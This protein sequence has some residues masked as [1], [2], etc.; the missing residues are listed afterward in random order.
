MER[1]K[2]LPKFLTLIILSGCFVHIGFSNTPYNIVET[3]NNTITINA[4]VLKRVIQIGRSGIQTSGIFVNGKNLLQK[5]YGEVSVNFFDA[6]PN[7]QPKGLVE[8][9]TGTF[10]LE[11]TTTESTDSLEIS[12]K[13]NIT[14]EGTT[15]IDLTTLHASQWGYFFNM[16]NYTISKPTPSTTRLC[17]RSRNHNIFID[18]IYEIYEGYPAIRKWVEVTN[19]SSQWKKIDNLVI[20]DI[21]ILE[22]YRHNT[23][24]T[25]SERG[26]VSSIRS[27]SDSSRSVGIINVSEIPS[28]LRTIEKSGSMGYTGDLF[29]WVLGPTEKFT[30]EAVF[31]FAFEGKT[32]TTI[33]GTSTPLD[34]TIENNFQHFLSDIIGLKKADAKSMSPLWCSWSNFGSLINDQNMRSMSDIASKIGIKTLLLDAGWA[35]AHEPNAIVPIGTGVDLQKFPYFN[36]TCQYMKRKGLQIG[37]WVTC[38]RHPQLSEDIK[39]LPRGYSLPK[40]QREDGLAMSYAGPW[41]YYY[42][43][44]LLRLHDQFGVTYFKQDLTNIKFG[45]FARGHE[46][47]TQKESILR[48]L[49]GLFEAQDIVTGASPDIQMELTHEIYWGTPGTPCDVA[50]LKHAHYFHIPPNDYS[51]AGHNKQRVNDQWS[52]IPAYQPDNLRK[53]LIQGCWNARQQFFAHRGLPLQSIEYYGA[54]TVNFKGSLTPQIQQRQLCSWLMGAPS[55]YAG[56][57]A[58]LSEENIK[59]YA[60]GFA[61]LDDLNNKYSIYQNFQYSGV[62]VPTDTDWHWWGKLNEEGYGAIVVLRGSEGDEQRQVN[63]PWVNPEKKYRV[64]LCFAN[65]ILGNFLGKALI[66]GK[67]RISLPVYSQEI[68]E[69][70]PTNR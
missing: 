22:Q 50:A 7:R 41:R 39:A 64:R 51:G 66:Q 12:K 11:D 18:I 2:S 29:E 26:A 48:G 58:S 8:N 43:N 27:F 36:E 56:D 9:E 16:I 53:Q 20:E 46:S 1:A 35:E 52:A 62:P 67:L 10:Y 28:A 49:R 30:S 57:L 24:F 4:G 14:G 59:T 38:F 70:M 37:L 44:D 25:P 63:I 68:I 17:I 5:S 45:D 3:E 69:L 21:E 15:W 32:T 54:A 65:K 6:L 31:I 33:S 34:R 47:R 19:N 23:D 13:E 60:E 55:V 42:A 40:V 61:L